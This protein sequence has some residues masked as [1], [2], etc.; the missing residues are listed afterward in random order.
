VR[1]TADDLQQLDE[2]APLGAAVGARYA[3]RGMTLLNQ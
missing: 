1:L 2:I 3:A